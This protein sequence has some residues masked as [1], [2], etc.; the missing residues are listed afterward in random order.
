MQVFFWL[1]TY[2]PFSFDVLES[3]EVLEFPKVLLVV[4]GNKVCIL[5]LSKSNEQTQ[6]HFQESTLSALSQWRCPE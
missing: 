1:S 5:D 3:N 6:K 2:F 4:S